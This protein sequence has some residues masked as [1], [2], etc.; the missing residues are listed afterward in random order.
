MIFKNPFFQNAYC[1]TDKSTD[2]DLQ[3]IIE[4]YHDGNVKVVFCNKRT[5][6]NFNRK[7][8]T[9]RFT[10]NNTLNDGHFFINKL[11]KRRDNYEH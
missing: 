3:N 8:S 1:F 2:E 7:T 4:K 6:R 9:C 10:I 5:L 11:S